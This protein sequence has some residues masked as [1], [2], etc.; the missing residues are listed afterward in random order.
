MRDKREIYARAVILQCFDDRAVLEMDWGES[1]R[2]IKEREDERI[3]MRNWLSN[4][5]YD[6]YMTDEERAFFELPVG[7]KKF[8]KNELELMDV[9]CKATDIILWALQIAELPDLSQFAVIDN[10]KSLNICREHDFFS[11]ADK[12]SIRYADELNFQKDIEFLWS[13]RMNQ[14]DIHATKGAN[15]NITDMIESEFGDRY[16][17]ALKGI[18]LYMP[19]IKTSSSDFVTC[20]LVVRELYKWQIQMLKGTTYWRYHAV[21]WILDEGMVW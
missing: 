11:E 1:T 16:Q 19:K 9:R 10:H 8:K 12:C 13:W 4:K 5:G 21:S 18:E 15:H 20:H 14:V 6:P 3:L 2:P 7:E 17:E